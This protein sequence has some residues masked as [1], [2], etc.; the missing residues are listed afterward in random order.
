MPEMMNQGKIR[1]ISFEIASIVARSACEFGKAVATV[2]VGGLFL[3]YT[4][5]CAVGFRQT[6]SSGEFLEATIL[7]FFFFGC[8]GISIHIVAVINGVVE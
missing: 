6:A 1:G 4:Y 7:A 5:I 2:L 8:L 3:F